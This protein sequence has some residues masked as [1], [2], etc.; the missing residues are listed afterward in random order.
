MR[1]EGPVTGAMFWGTVGF[2]L[3]G[4]LIAAYYWLAA[5]AAELDDHEADARAQ[6]AEGR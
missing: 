6:A 3:A 5:P 2:I 4:L 1:P